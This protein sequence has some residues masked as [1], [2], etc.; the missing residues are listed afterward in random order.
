M[1]LR[2]AYR[3]GDPA[4]WRLGGDHAPSVDRV[5]AVPVVD[6]DMAAAVVDVDMRVEWG[7]AK[8]TDDVDSVVSW[9]D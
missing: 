3:I 9:K 8:D 5:P 2:L 4:P 7:D 6:T 1:A